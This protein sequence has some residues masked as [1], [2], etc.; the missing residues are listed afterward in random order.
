MSLMKDFKDE[1]VRRGGPKPLIE[2]MFDQMEEKDAKDLRDALAD[3]TIPCKAIASVLARRG[4]KISVATIQ[5][6]RSANGFV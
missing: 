2:K 3:T 4:H 5:K 1:P 6:Y